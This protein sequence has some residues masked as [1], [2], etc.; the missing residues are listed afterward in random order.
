MAALVHT[1]TL[2]RTKVQMLTQLCCRLGA[3]LIG[4]GGAAGAREAAGRV[5]RTPA[6][7]RHAGAWLASSYATRDGLKLLVS[8][9]VSY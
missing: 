1:Y 7:L 2:S 4:Q 9:A 6:A 5:R 8:A 3:A